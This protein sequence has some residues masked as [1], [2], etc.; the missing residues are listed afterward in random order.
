MT[1]DVKKMV[2][3]FYKLIGWSALALTLKMAPSAA[4]DNPVA[5][6]PIKQKPL[7]LLS[8]APPSHFGGNLS[9]Y[10]WIA[11]VS[12]HFGIGPYSRNVDASF[13]D[14][15]SQSRQFP[16]G[17]MGRMEGYY[18]RLGLFVDGNYMN[19]NLKPRYGEIS[20]GLD[21]HLGLMDVGVIYRLFGPPPSEIPS[22]IGQKKSNRLD[23]YLG[24]RTL[25]VDN[26]LQSPGWIGQIRPGISKS[27]ALTSPILGGRMTVDFTPEIFVSADGNVGG[28]GVQNVSFTG[29]IQGL[30]GYRFSAYE[31]PA[32]VELGYKALKYSIEPQGPLATNVLLNGPFLGL[33]SY[34]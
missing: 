29:G 22:L 17:F 31:M 7:P 14:I 1:L 20:Q 34:W 32:S 12:G 6:E 16:I 25:W 33:T 19:I 3:G 11:G 26:S 10:T 2:F 15:N 24:S 28:F 9:L 18:D 30:I 13:I 4:A 8:Q 5:D 21:S 23:L 27:N